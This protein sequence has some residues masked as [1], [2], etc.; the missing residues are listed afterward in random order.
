LEN[1]EET[2][3]KDLFGT[4]LGAAFVAFAIPLTASA[5][6]T[7]CNGSLVGIFD[8]NLVVPSGARCEVRGA[9]RLDRRR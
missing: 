5:D 1:P 9:A 8:G 3:M 7:P 2:G 6:D 4:L